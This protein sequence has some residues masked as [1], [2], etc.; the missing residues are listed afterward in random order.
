MV[1]LASNGATPVAGAAQ[2]DPRRAAVRLLISASDATPLFVVLMA[3]LVAA[4]GSALLL[5][6]LGK[7]VR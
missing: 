4:L 5:R 7:N 6:R 2:D 3:G 1:H